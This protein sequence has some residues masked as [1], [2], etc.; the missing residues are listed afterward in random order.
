MS[1]SLEGCLDTPTEDV[2]CVQVEVKRE[3]EY[4]TFWTP[5]AYAILGK[6]VRVKEVDYSW[7][8]PWEIIK[9]YDKVL[10]KEIEVED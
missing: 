4:R 1:M 3:N 2:P 5:M 6:I 10:T 8:E 9:V 7:T